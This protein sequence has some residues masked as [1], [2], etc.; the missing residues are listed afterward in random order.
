MLYWLNSW[1]W[2][3]LENI[4]IFW[5]VWTR[6]LQF[7]VTCVEQRHI[8]LP[9]EDLE[10]L[11]VNVNPQYLISWPPLLDLM[12]TA[13]IKFN[14]KC[15]LSSLSF[16]ILWMPMK[17]L[18]FRTDSWLDMVLSMLCKPYCRNFSIILMTSFCYFSTS[19]RLTT[20]SKWEKP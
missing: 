16:K 3:V 15:V 4:I 17:I 13:E 1:L 9:D 10:L 11:Q 7:L 6:A 5:K 8:S 19:F 14:L 18:Q 12:K 20:F 2:W